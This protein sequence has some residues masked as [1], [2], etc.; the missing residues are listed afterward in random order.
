MK[1]NKR[2]GRVLSARNETKLRDAAGAVEAAAVA[3]RDVLDAATEEGRADMKNKEVR[4]FGA[5][6]LRMVMEDGKPVLR[7][8][9]AMFNQ[10]SVDF[11]GWREI[12]RPGAF[13]ASLAAG[14]D[15]R[16]LV[17]H[18]SGLSTIG[19]TRNGTLRLLEDGMGLAVEI[20]PPDTQAGR[21]VVT[22]VERGDLNQMSFAFWTRRDNWLDT[23]EMV[24]RELHEVDIND[25]D[26]AV[27]TY[28]AYPSTNIGLR[29]LMNLPEIPNDLRQG[30]DSDKADAAGVQVRQALRMRRLQLLTL[31]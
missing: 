27:V 15:V 1:L 24:L 4:F 22:L 25:G 14:P 10:L 5:Q 17:N 28:P 23:G 18:E 12:I 29:S 31:E 8:Y 7:G 6:E 30:P 20:D 3:I 16:A 21:D 11:G 2:A 26:V 9:A 13:T 19:R